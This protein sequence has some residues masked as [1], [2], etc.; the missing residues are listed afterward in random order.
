LL[1]LGLSDDGGK[2]NGVWLKRPEGIKYFFFH[3]LTSCPG[4]QTLLQEREKN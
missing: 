1:N 3:K 2:N 4:A